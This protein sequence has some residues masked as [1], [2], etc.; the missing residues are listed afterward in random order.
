MRTSAGNTYVCISLCFSLPFSGKLVVMFSRLPIN[1]QILG[2]PSV[3]EV[4]NAFQAI[5]AHEKER[6][7]ERYTRIALPSVPVDFPKPAGT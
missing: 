7:T 3:R 2:G 6:G 4:L 1:P 5:Q